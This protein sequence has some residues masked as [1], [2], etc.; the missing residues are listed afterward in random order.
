M[1]VV[2]DGVGLYVDVEGCGLVADGDAMVPGPTLVL[3]HRGPGQMVSAT[4]IVGVM[5]SRWRRGRAPASGF[6]GTIDRDPTA[7]VPMTDLS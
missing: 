1:R 5:G 2:V 7:G 4:S 3:L 6:G